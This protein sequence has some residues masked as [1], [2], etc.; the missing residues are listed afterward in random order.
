MSAADGVGGEGDPSGTNAKYTYALA[1]N[2]SSDKVVG[3]WNSTASVVF[4]TSA[5]FGASGP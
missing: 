2:V 4:T 3:D 5:P 1:P